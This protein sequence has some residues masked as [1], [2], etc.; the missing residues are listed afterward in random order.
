MSLREQLFLQA[1]E[2]LPQRVAHANGSA[3]TTSAAYQQVAVD[4]HQTIID[5]VELGRLQQL[6]PDQVK[7]ELAQLV[8]RI[9]DEGKHQLNE[10]E[11]RR[12]VSD[13]Q[14]EMLGYGPLEPLLA[15][16]TI[17]DIL[18]NT[19][20]HVY[21]ER[22]GKL[23]LTSVTFHD[24]AHL[25]RVIEKM[26]SR[27]GRRIDESSPMV[28]ARLPDGSRINAIIPPSAIDGPLLSIRRFAV[29]PLTIQDLVG[30]R[31][32][33]PEM[34]QLLDAM[35]KAKLNILISGGT[36][37]GKT[38]LLNILS[39]YIPADERIVTIEDAAELQLRQNHVLRLETRPVNIEGRGE[40]TQRALVK[41]A[42]RMRPDRIILGE[43]RG[44]EALDML[45]AMNTG[46]EGSLATIH[47]N[48]PRDAL[49]RLENM[50]S[51]A[52]LSLPTKTM[53]QQITSALTVVVQVSRL[54]DGFRKLV[55]VQEIT[56]ME[57][58]IVN[59][60]EIFAFR[61]KG[62]D[63]DGRIKGHFCATG[64]RPKFSERLQAFGIHLPES[65]Y[66]PSVQYEV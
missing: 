43:V 55:S 20:K 11:R 5:R 24:D 46:H 18:V 58:E 48:T 45:H 47:A 9:I 28:D 60:Q 1:G 10:A 17:S 27:V 38:T 53:R 61:R 37:S 52:G 25:M 14:D 13:V 26:V 6:E 40:I 65:L 31:T 66:D 36:G 33:T 19:Y 50:I 56:G 21:V 64:V 42:L 59:M 16:P 32:L 3:A 29:N 44:A 54:T 62:I 57:G 34:A 63:R 12:L 41:N 2:A 51:M 49:T 39:G 23:E 35:V 8:E 15:D 7:R 4:I 30:F 22:R